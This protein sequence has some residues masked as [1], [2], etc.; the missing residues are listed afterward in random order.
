MS[1][2][3][4][5][6]NIN[7]HTF[8]NSIVAANEKSKALFQKPL[9]KIFVIHSP[10]SEKTLRED[11]GWVKHIES[12]GI[13]AHEIHQKVIELTS[14][15]TVSTEKFIRHIEF[16]FN[17]IGIDRSDEWI[18][19]LT[20]GTSVQKNLLSISSYILDIHHQYM[21]DISI[22]NSITQERN[23]LP[24][25]IMIQC[26]QP[27]PETTQMD[28]FAYLD[29]SEVIR[30][31]KVIDHH[32]DEFVRIG[33]ETVD[34]NFFREN[35]LHSVKLKLEGDR[36]EDNTIYRIATTSIA[37]SL[38]ELITELAKRIRGVEGET[39][40]RKIRILEQRIEKN[41]Q[42]SFDFEFFRKFNDFILYLRNSTTHKG[43]TLNDLEKFKAELAVKM[44][45]PF[46]EFYTKFV[47]PAVE[48]SN[49]KEVSTA[50]GKKAIR[51]L[52]P[53]K[54]NQINTCYFGLDG[55]NTGGNLEG[56]FMGPDTGE[57]A[58]RKMSD[59]VSKAIRNIGKKV[60][61]AGGTVI[62]EAGDDLL[63]K[64]SF[65]YGDLEGFQKAYYRETGGYTCS[66]AFGKT[67]HETFL[68]MKLAKANP[69]KNTIMGIEL[70]SE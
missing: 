41:L 38:E 23:F 70:I 32:S 40:G 69:G 60:R 63:F 10:L 17:G 50:S 7:Q 61:K 6:G 21:V 68:A 55:D 8:A 37:A 66:V 56:L 3:L 67:F 19:D 34:E 33:K 65:S 12:A 42:S 28:G 62:F 11:R 64:G 36:K 1:F 53:E 15:K 43:E 45:F 16:L 54:L 39:L 31:K 58:F 18:V 20:N 57:Q 35:L 2:L 29:L 25:E 46:L 26:Y 9:E 22:L 27:A 24:A 59:R 47:E 4:L 13:D 30:Y 5:H 52:S 49:S 44:A 14:G 51:K 48:S